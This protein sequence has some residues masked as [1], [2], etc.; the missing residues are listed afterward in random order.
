MCV[1]MRG[2]VNINLPEQIGPEVDRVCRSLLDCLRD[3]SA[4]VTAVQDAVYAYWN[5]TMS[6]ARIMGKCIGK[7]PSEEALVWERRGLQD[8]SSLSS[9]VRNAQ[10]AC[11]I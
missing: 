3:P 9:Y 11:P 2:E 10:S 4:Y 8:H 5:R 1:G 6:R 7:E